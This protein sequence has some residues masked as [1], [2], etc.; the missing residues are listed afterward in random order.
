[1][2]ATCY[3]IFCVIAGIYLAEINFHPVRREMPKEMAESPQKF[4]AGIYDA[5]EVSRRS[6]DAVHLGA[7]YVRGASDNGETVVILHG[8]SDNRLASAGLAPLFLRHGYRVLLPDSRAHGESGGIA[9]FGLKEAGDIH[10]WV[11]WLYENDRPRCTYGLGQ[12][13]GAA[14]LLQALTEENRFCAVAVDSPFASFREAAYEHLGEFFGLGPHWFGRTIGRPVLFVGTTYGRLRYHVNLLDA[15]PQRALIGSGQPVL[16]IH[17]LDDND[18]LPE[19]SI[20]L[21]KAASSHTELWLVAH[22]QHIGAYATRPQEF[23]ERV[24]NWFA[25]NRGQ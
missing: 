19:N 1:M 22:A 2:I 17:G 9:T 16:L 11:S 8:L 6:A 15:D 7:W 12:S 18:L 25:V 5:R 21:H 23:E 14:I 20:E 13:M 4:F 3:L 10:D 24:L